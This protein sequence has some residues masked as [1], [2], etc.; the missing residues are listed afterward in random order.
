M[1]GI[2]IVLKYP[3]LLFLFNWDIENVS[4]YEFGFEKLFAKIFEE[5]QNSAKLWKSSTKIPTQFGRK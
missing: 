1:S 5:W 3:K 2:I 4:E